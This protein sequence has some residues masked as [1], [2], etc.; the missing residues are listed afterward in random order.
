MKIRN[1]LAVGVAIAILFS[2]LSIRNP[3][4]DPGWPDFIVQIDDG[5][6]LGSLDGLRGIHYFTAR[7]GHLTLESMRGGA[8]VTMSA[9]LVGANRGDV[10]R[11]TP[12]VVIEKGRWYQDTG[13][14]TV[15]SSLRS[16]L[17]FKI[18]DEL[19][20]DGK[21]LR[22]VGILQRTGTQFDRMVFTNKD[23]VPAGFPTY[24]YLF[25]NTGGKWSDAELATRGLARVPDP[26]GQSGDET[27][28]LFTK[29]VVS[30][31]VGLFVGWNGFRTRR[32]VVVSPTGTQLRW[33][34]LMS[35]PLLGWVIGI[36]TGIAITSALNMAMMSGLELSLFRPSWQAVA[37]TACLVFFASVIGGRLARAGPT[38]ATIT[39]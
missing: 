2:V 29:I 16:F 20:V 13:E 22:I 31:L 8:K 24:A 14:A 9:T 3:Y 28:V 30:G 6:D 39:R 26:Y 34:V 17:G 10:Q 37:F 5:G 38:Q 25:T 18:G 23:D 27:T 1:V 21:M 36:L 35:P 32:R 4:R 19:A 33:T 12:P 15:G 11:S 7:H